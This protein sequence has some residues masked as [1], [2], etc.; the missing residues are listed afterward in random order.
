[1]GYA[2]RDQI[3]GQ[4]SF[5]AFEEVLKIAKERKVDFL[6]LGGDLFHENKPSRQT[7]CRCIQLLR[8]YCLTSDRIRFEF[9]SDSTVNFKHSQFPHVNF[10]D[11]N[12]N[13]GLP[14]FTIHG[15][16]DDPT[17]NPSL[18][19]LDMLHEAGLI[20][21]FG[22]ID[23][24]DAITIKPLL[25]EKGN[26]KL[27]LFG[28]GAVRDERLHNLFFAKKVQ[29]HAPLAQDEQNKWFNVFVLHQ[30]REKRGEHNFIPETFLPS[31]LDLVIWGHEHP[32]RLSKSDIY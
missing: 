9:V 1:M 2:E 25:L 23:N 31:F 12:L 5:L 10:H 26:V 16:H 29:F 3:R 30:N 15:N 20:N 27:A 19:A 14:V 24:Y 21:L 11:R 13:V 8:Q 6:L 17:G 18:C 4:D 22:K 28:L 32:C 7:L